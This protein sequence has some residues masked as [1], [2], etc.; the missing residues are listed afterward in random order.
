MIMGN[1]L[2]FVCD[3]DI[4]AV[5]AAT[6]NGEALPE[7]LISQS[8]VDQANLLTP[9]KAQRELYNHFSQDTHEAKF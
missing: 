4:D 7:P 5:M 2:Y 8:K 1:S 9:D 3:F 6:V